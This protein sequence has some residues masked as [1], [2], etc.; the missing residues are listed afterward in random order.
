MLVR[1]VMVIV[2]AI[3]DLQRGLALDAVLHPLHKSGHEGSEARME[4]SYSIYELENYR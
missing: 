2:Q 3:T 1:E 4:V